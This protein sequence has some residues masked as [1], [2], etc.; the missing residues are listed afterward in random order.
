MP[1]AEEYEEDVFPEYNP[2]DENDVEGIGM[3]DVVTEEV[4][5]SKREAT[6]GEVAKV[7]EGGA[8]HAF[9]GDSGLMSNIARDLSNEVEDLET[10]KEMMY[11]FY[12]DG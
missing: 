10:T 2:S 5:V 6:E 8:S 7:V 4:T 9:E 3:H 12:C 11:L 1:N